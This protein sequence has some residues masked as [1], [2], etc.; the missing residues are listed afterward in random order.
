MKYEI[1]YEEVI[2][3]INSVTIEVEDADEGEDVANELYDL[4][5]RFDHPD[6]IFYALS[7]MGYD[8]LETCEGAEDCRYEFL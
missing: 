2:R 1:E 7:N 4:S 6:D 5:N 3:R 8:V